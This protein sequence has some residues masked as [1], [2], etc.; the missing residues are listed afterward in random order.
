MLQRFNEVITGERISFCIPKFNLT[1][2]EFICPPELS[3]EEIPFINFTDP[4]RLEFIES[5]TIRGT[6]ITRGPLI[7]IPSDICRL[8]KLKVCNKT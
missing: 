3:F 4:I 2:I 7:K 5:L 8:T 6:S 1:S